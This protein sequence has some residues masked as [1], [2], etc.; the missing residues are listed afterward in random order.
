MRRDADSIAARSRVRRFGGVEWRR[1]VA[2]G[3]EWRG[4]IRDPDAGCPACHGSRPVAGRLATLA[5]SPV[6][7]GSRPGAARPATVAAGRWWLPCSG[8]TLR[9][10]TGR[11]PPDMAAGSAEPRLVELLL[12]KGA[13]ADIYAVTVGGDIPLH[14]AARG[15]ESQLE[16]IRLLLDWGAD[17]EIDRANNNGKTA[18]HRAAGSPRA[19]PAAI[20]LLPERGADIL[21]GTKQ[22]ETPLHAAAQYGPRPEVL[23]ALVD[24]GADVNGR[25]NVGWTPSCVLPAAGSVIPNF[26]E[27]EAPRVKRR[28]TWKSSS[29]C[30]RTAPTCR[31]GLTMGRRRASTPNW[32]R[33]LPPTG[34]APGVPATLREQSRRTS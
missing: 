15:S 26:S 9:G 24:H 23:L 13:D 28:G 8:S 12:V 1:G 21:A 31:P 17:E 19:D 14:D 10:P 3:R 4:S 32:P 11:T 18:R 34:P 25:D 29:C 27:P 5:F 7:A 33:F 20:E 22:G 2:A 30:L 16:V 6:S